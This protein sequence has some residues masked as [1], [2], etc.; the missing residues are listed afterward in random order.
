MHPQKS[1]PLTFYRTE[2]DIRMAYPEMIK[3]ILAFCE[4]QVTSFCRAV[5]KP[6]VDEE[7]YMDLVGFRWPRGS[8]DVR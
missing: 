8:A 6:V 4:P 5:E 2:S 3:D 1:N 7:R